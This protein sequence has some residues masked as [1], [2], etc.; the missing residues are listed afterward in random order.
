MYADADECV[1]ERVAQNT[2][3]VAVGVSLREKNQSDQNLIKYLIRKWICWLLSDKH[4]SDHSNFI[5]CIVNLNMTPV[6]NFERNGP[7]VC[8]TQYIEN[9]IIKIW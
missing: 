6:S 9:K 2:I 5:L 7:L 4:F 8:V 1:F 3:R